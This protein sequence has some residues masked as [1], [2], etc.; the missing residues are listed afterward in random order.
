LIVASP[1]EISWELQYQLDLEYSVGRLWFD[2]PRADQR[3]GTYA[4]AVVDYEKGLLAARPR[5]LTLWG[6][7]QRGDP[8][9]QM[10]SDLLLKPLLHGQDGGPPVSERAE[11]PP[12]EAI[13]E[14]AATRQRLLELLGGGPAQPALVFTAGHG[15]RY[16]SGDGD[17]LERQGALLGHHHGRWPDPVL[18]AAD[19]GESFDGRGLVAFFFA[20]FGA[21]TPARDD[22]E[23][24]APRAPRPFVARLPQAMLGHPTRPAL[25]VVGHVD[26]AWAYSFEPGGLS[27]SQVDHFE[28]FLGR[29]L[30]GE[31]V[32]HATADIHGRAA[33][34]AS[35]LAD[36]LAPLARVPIGD[37]A[38][39]LAFLER[40]D[41]RNYVLLGDPAV[42][43]RAP[44]VP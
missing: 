19:V 39:A 11:A 32:G 42:R 3:F 27:G 12:A 25:A 7:R 33:V 31:P 38:L 30:R 24:G 40:N 8:A 4:R 36:A 29:V 9:T 1:E 18:A 20:C 15:L 26:R 22:F 35:Q 5:R 10:A 21:G 41:A 2:G 23:D 28:S 6:P 13:L 43:L 17:Q 34:L 44:T 37:E 14:E 16:P